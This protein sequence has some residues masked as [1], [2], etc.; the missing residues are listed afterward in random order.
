VRARGRPF[1]FRGYPVWFRGGG[2]PCLAA[3]VWDDAR[4]VARLSK[5]LLRYR[6]RYAAGGFLLLATAS[7]AMLVPYL[8]K[9]A[10]NA[11]EARRPFREV[12]TL[13]GAM[14]AIAVVQMVVRTYSRF[15]VFN[16]GRDVEYDLRNDLFAHLLRLP[17]SFYMRQQTG[18]L[19]S[20]LVNDVTAV[21]ML[22]GPGILNL[23]NTPVYYVYGLAIMLSLDW[24]LTLVSLTPYPILL[25][26]VKH[27]SRQLMERTVKVQTGL[28][29]LSSRV[30]ENISGMHVV[31]AYARASFEQEKF[32]AANAIF[33]EESV[34]LA[35][36]RGRMFPSMR[37]ASGLG[38][39]VVLWY[40]GSHV[41]DGRLSIG[42]FVAF[43]AYLNMLAWPTM[44]LGWMISIVQRGRAA[45]QRLEH[46]YAVEPEIADPAAPADLTAARTARAAAAA[47]P[48][49]ELDD[50]SFTYPGSSIRANGGPRHFE[51]QHID[52]ELPQGKKLAI[53]GRT[54]SGKSTIVN[55][56]PR[57]FDVAGGA[58][59]VQGRDAREY[60]LADLRGRIGMVPQD[61]F[62]FSATV[63][64]NVAFGDDEPD[65]AR[66]RAALAAA[67]LAPDVES[68]PAGYDTV[69]GERGVMLSGGQRQRLTLARALYD[70]P[71]LL[72]LDDAL[73]SVDTRTEQ[74]I[75]DNLRDLR[76]ARTTIVVAHRL[77]AVQDADVIAVVDDGQI[78]E[79]GDHAGLLRRGGLYADLF[80]RQR[81]EE[82]LEAEIEAR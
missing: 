31:K 5:Y 80:R 40:G 69:V 56:L 61:P 67:G 53:V 37:V 45:M 77:S 4:A 72:V 6:W 10:V 30:Q 66:V 14:V 62:L 35:D 16:A 60:R 48:A 58:V 17:Q 64:E 70:D 15:V 29:E 9:L 68:F 1:S 11:V 79:I 73:S 7:L 20:R 54:G 49:V 23:L 63:R 12:A 19:M 44:A 71:S 13:A 41:I 50:V 43:I 52:L 74:G 8:L 27:Y 26:I 51:L 21:R 28:A 82:E 18:D 81:I 3:A 46:I 75:L 24:R 34:R 57:L 32:D 39:L 33:T 65:E 47:A 76:R 42:D 78:V 55:L 38:I 59:R 36:V 22:L 2:R 25:W